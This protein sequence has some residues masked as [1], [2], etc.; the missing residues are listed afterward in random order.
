MVGIRFLLLASPAAHILQAPGRVPPFY[1]ADR[2]KGKNTVNTF[3]DL[4]LR[5][6]FK[7]GF[8]NIWGYKFDSGILKLTK[9]LWGGSI[10]P[11]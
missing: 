11:V 3:C 1:E 10:L 7:Q 8:R 2:L 9:T 6:I 5:I 4:D